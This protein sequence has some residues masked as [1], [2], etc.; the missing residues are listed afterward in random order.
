[1]Y[2]YIK[3]LS[4]LFLNNNKSLKINYEIKE[5]IKIKT[6][7]SM[8]KKIDLFKKNIINDKKINII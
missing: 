2:I 7:E 3:M 1:M 6:K 4:I 8:N 5:Y